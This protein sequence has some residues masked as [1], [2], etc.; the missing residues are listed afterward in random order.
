MLTVKIKECS[1]P[2]V[3]QLTY[4][5]L[6]KELK[7][8]PDSQLMVGSWDL[9]GVKNRYV[10]FVESDC[11]VSSGYFSSQMGLF[12]KDPMFRKIAVMGSSTGINNWANKIYGYRLGNTY[13]DGVIPITDKK[14]T[15]P[16][17]VQVAF[18]PGAII[19]VSM[20]EKAVLELEPKNSWE[21]DLVYY[22]TMFSLAFWRQGDG[23][24]V[25]LNP[26][27]TYVTTEDYVND[28]GKFDPDGGDLIKY[29]KDQSI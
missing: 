3:T 9:T 21:N 18:L 14:S 17:P 12:R 16:Y 20:L 4:E 8:I 15:S 2:T 19:R 10:C 1:E 13:S 5:N 27:A 6:F 7:D 23:N 28:I 26:N 25:H 22:S 11:L 29:F 24:R